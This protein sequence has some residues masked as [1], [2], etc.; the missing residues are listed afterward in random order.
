MKHKI[1][2]AIIEFTVRYANSCK[3]SLS[4]INL[5]HCYIFA[6]TIYKILKKRGFNVKLHTCTD[7]GGHACIEI[8]SRFYDSEH[9]EGVDNVQQLMEET[10]LCKTI[11]LEYIEEMD[12]EEFFH[13]W[14]K[15]GLFNYLF[16][17]SRFMHGNAIRCGQI[18][19][20]FLKELA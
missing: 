6:Y 16:D 19:A 2:K 12:E 14:I 9:A 5:G 11:P 8:E 10:L 1:R 7:F 18:F 15:W 17:D 3:I 13:Y 20:K 4:Q